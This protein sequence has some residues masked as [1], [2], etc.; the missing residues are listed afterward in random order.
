MLET[1]VV[2]LE[3][4]MVLYV[5]LVLCGDLYQDSVQ[6]FSIIFGLVITTRVILEFIPGAALTQ[7][8]IFLQRSD[9]TS[10]DLMIP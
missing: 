6:K 9:S 4:F 5:N 3:A 7:T 10:I 1:Y 2:N 8:I